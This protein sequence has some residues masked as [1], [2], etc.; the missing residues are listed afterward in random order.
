MTD[1]EVIAV[2]YYSSS[3]VLVFTKNGKV[4]NFYY[5]IAG[6]CSEAKMIAQLDLSNKDPDSSKVENK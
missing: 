5:S 2:C 3:T 6:G 4:F 1:D